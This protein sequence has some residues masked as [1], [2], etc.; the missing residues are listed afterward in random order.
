MMALEIEER[1]KFCWAA[2]MASLPFRA[3]DPLI[4][5]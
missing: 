5:L 3:L 2:R 1:S 4:I